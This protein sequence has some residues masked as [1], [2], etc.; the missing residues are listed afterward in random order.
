MRIKI[1]LAQIIADDNRR[2]NVEKGLGQLAEAAR[3]GAQIICF[4]EMSFCRFFPQYHADAQYFDWAEPVPGPLVERFQNACRKHAIGA[5][6]N[7]YEKGEPGQYFDCS[8]VIDGTGAYIGK[9]QMMHIAELPGYNEKYYYWEGKTGYPVY[10]DRGLRF[11]IAIC[12]DR[13]FPEQMRILA[14][15]GAQ[16]IF[17]PTAT[18]LTEL[19]T[20]WEIEMQAASV[21]NQVFIAVVNHAGRDDKIQYFGKSFVT[22]P[23]GTILAMAGESD[24]ELLTVDIDTDEI[25][26]TRRL[27]PFLRDRRPETY[28]ELIDI[29]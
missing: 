20:I 4:P 9:S 2:V 22:S 27:L 24:E 13:H 7:L 29:E 16:V 18:S 28:D 25:E 12:Y 1:A 15:N 14:L 3:R 6:F 17:V 26:K 11:G 23:Q 10:E 8:P 19:N 5:V 21:A